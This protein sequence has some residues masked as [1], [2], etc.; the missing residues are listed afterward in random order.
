MQGLV[1]AHCLF[2]DFVECVCVRAHVACMLEVLALPSKP[3]ASLHF[4]WILCSQADHHPEDLHGKISV[5]A[6]IHLLTKDY[7]HYL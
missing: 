5:I 7:Q 4:T 6:F 1:I 3:G 2:E